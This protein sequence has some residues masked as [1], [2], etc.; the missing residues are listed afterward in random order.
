MGARL[1]IRT[2]IAPRIEELI[3]KKREGNA[4]VFGDEERPK[5]N[6]VDLMSALQASIER[7]SAKGRPKRPRP[8]SPPP[9]SHPASRSP[10]TAKSSDSTP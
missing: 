9:R 4:V 6:V 5:S 2:P 10:I 3:E 8:R 7:S 1:A